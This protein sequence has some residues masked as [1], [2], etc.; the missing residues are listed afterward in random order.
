MLLLLLLLSSLKA[1]SL[2]C[3]SR[4]L[5]VFSF[6]LTE[7][8]AQTALS[9]VLQ[10]RLKRVRKQ[11]VIEQNKQRSHVSV[12]LTVKKICVRRVFAAIVLTIIRKWLNGLHI[13]VGRS[14]V[15]FIHRF[16]YYQH[17]SIE[18]IFQWRAQWMVFL[19]CVGIP[20]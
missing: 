13:K 6:F 16:N 12:R 2:L 3:S 14:S 9:P 5:I 1:F 10:F 15:G 19:L 11:K 17:L 18:Y 8:G 7:Y 20:V 4:T